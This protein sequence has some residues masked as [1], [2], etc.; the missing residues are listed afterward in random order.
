MTCTVL[1][2]SYLK[3][4]TFS[5]E[6]TGFWRSNAETANLSL[7]I[8]CKRI[9]FYQKF[10]YKKEKFRLAIYGTPE[11]YP[12]FIFLQSVCFRAERVFPLFPAP[13]VSAERG[14]FR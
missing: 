2:E 14:I 11:F 4:C 7:G 1:Q 8:P 13:P 3:I 10:V 6:F 5:L 9:L 12:V